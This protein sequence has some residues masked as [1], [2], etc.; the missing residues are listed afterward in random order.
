MT[1]KTLTKKMM[2]TTTLD[3]SAQEMPRLSRQVVEKGADVGY[4]R[5]AL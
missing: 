5:T 1:M 4:G 2:M 3:R